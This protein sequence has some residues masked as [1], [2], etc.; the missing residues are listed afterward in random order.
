MSILLNES[1]IESAKT[2]F[3]TKKAI[4]L[5]RKDDSI[6]T[7]EDAILKI[8]S[9]KPTIPE[10]YYRE[11]MKD[12]QGLLVIY[13]FDSNYAFNKLGINKPEH[14]NL[15]E[16]FQEYV[17]ENKIDTEIPLV[18]YAI[19][20]PPIENDPGGIYLQG[21]YDID[22]DEDVEE[23]VEAFEGIEDSKEQ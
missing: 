20:F 21:D 10:R 23:D 11:R 12:T 4:E 3:F 17:L 15:K 7:L 16:R 2:S 14:E 9:D 5:K 8:K 19:E 1:E 6:K 22:E 18:G 13:L